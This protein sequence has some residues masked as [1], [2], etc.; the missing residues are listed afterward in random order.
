MPIIRLKKVNKAIELYKKQSDIP[1]GIAPLTKEFV[2]AANAFNDLSK[3]EKEE[4]LLLLGFDEQEI[5]D[6]MVE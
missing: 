6:I 2:N 5:K 4:M 3:A 1:R